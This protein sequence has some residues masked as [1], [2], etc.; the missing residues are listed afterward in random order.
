MCQA[1]IVL[2]DQ[3]KRGHIVMTDDNIVWKGNLFD[4]G[5]S[6]C[7]EHTVEHVWA[8]PSQH[9]HQHNHHQLQHDSHLTASSHSD[10]TFVPHTYGWNAGSQHEMTA[11][12]SAA[13][14][15]SSPSQT[16]FAFARPAYHPSVYNH[17]SSPTFA[18]SSSASSLSSSFPSFTSKGSAKLK[19]NRAA[20]NQMAAESSSHPLMSS[21][22][23]IT[24][25][26]QYP[27][28]ISS[29]KRPSQFLSPSVSS[30]F[31][32]TPVAKKNQVDQQL[33][34]NERRNSKEEDGE[35]EDVAERLIT[36]E[37]MK[38]FGQDLF[39]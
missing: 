34:A 11:G 1:N 9:H 39:I 22:F 13:N 35:E 7:A 5:D 26:F 8:Y 14:H 25:G 19:T 31:L 6:D 28:S 12:V 2:Q 17:L 21:L 27:I 20:V 23:P 32:S 4:Q 36:Q 29:S 24:F 16:Y 3:K 18:S 30:S 10:Y 15:W 38:E 33:K 37:V